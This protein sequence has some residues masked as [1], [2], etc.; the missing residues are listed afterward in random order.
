MPV[1]GNR[2]PAATGRAA[3]ATAATIAAVRAAAAAKALHAGELY[4]AAQ[5]GRV[6]E[7]GRLLALG[8]DP[9]S[10]LS[11]NGWQAALHAAA[12]NDH[13]AV[14]GRLVEAGADPNLA[15]VHQCMEYW[16]VEY[17]ICTSHSHCRCC[18]HT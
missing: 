18:M 12:H 16:C 15:C 5:E 1:G 4:V 13:E 7:V 3:P 11:R 14:V 10:R 6:E 8:V 17:V 9:N 2:A